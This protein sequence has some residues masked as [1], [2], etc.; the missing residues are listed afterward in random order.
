LP[1]TENLAKTIQKVGAN[2]KMFLMIYFLPVSDIDRFDR[3]EPQ[4]ASRGWRAK[5]FS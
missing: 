5:C 1:P 2:S 4:L 3:N